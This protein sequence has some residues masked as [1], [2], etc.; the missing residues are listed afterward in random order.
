MT[1]TN[2]KFIRKETII[3]LNESRSHYF[4]NALDQTVLIRH[5]RNKGGFYI[6][7][8]THKHTT[9]KTDINLYYYLF[10]MKVTINKE[11]LEE[12]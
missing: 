4:L 8:H 5:L 9:N 11:E 6:H 2:I 3:N 7:R 12:R 1:I 10:K